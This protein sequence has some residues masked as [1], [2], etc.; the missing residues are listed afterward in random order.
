MSGRQ[1]ELVCPAGTPAALRTAVDAGAH[2]VYCGFADET[3]ARNFWLNFSRDEMAAGIDYAHKRGSKVLVAINAFPRAGAQDFWHRAVADAD[4]RGADAV[5][6]ADLGL[7]GHAAEKSIRNCA[8]I[9]PSRRPPPTPTPSISM[10][11]NSGLSAS[12]CRASSPFRRSPPSTGKSKRR[13]RYSFRRAVRDGGGRCSL[14]SYATGRSPNMNGVCSPASRVEYREEDDELV[15]RLGGFAIDRSPQGAPAPIRLFC[16]GCFRAG[17]HEGHVFEDPVSL[18]AV[19]LIPQLAEAGVSAQDRR[20]PA[21]PRLYA[22][23]RQF[24]PQGG[25]RPCRGPADAGQRPAQSHRGPADDGQPI[26]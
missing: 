14:S 16:K 19:S 5:I 9:S 2:T 7:L 23:R 18:D 15:S 6:V 8:C 4:E 20:S 21:Q 22:C 17:D 1:L 25:R 3:N 24:V 10:R 13:R 12:C 11:A 26:A